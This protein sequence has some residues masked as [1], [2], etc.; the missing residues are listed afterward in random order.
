MRERDEIAA[1][2]PFGRCGPATEKADTVLAGA[3]CVH[4]IDLLATAPVALKDDLG[5]I[6]RIATA[7]VDAG[8][9]GQLFRTAAIS[10]HAIDIGVASHRHR[11]QNPLAI[12]RPARRKCGVARFGDKALAVGFNII[13]IDTRHAVEVGEVDD[14]P[15]IGRIARGQRHGLAGGDKAVVG[16]IR[17]HDR[18]PLH[19]VILGAGLGDIGDAAVKERALARQARIDRIGAFMGGAAPIAGAKGPCGASQSLMQ[20]H[21]IEVT[22]DR[23]PTALSILYAAMHQ[24]FGPARAPH[25]KIGRGDLFKQHALQRTRAHRLEQAI[26]LEIRRDHLRNRAAKLGGATGGGPS[27]HVIVGRKGGDIDV[28]RLPCAVIRHGDRKAIIRRFGRRAL[29]GRRAKQRLRREPLGAGGRRHRRQQQGDTLCISGRY[30]HWDR[31]LSKRT[32]VRC[33]QAS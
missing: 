14:P 15:V 16:A 5:A 10:G 17:I 26:I 25:G 24:H 27:G 28:E 31:F 20:A 6:G 7:D 29:R 9:I 18:Q 8:G 21:V 23:Q 32:L 4:H 19:A 22:A 12:G 13:D 2:A 33:F 1:R 3:I 30:R 11:I